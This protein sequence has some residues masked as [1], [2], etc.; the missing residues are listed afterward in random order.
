M[1]VH[2]VSIER[3]LLLR[4]LIPNMVIGLLE[5]VERRPILNSTGHFDGVVGHKRFVAVRHS[6]TSDTEVVLPIC[7][8]LELVF[9]ED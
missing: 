9:H 4:C 5:H 7:N 2:V 3:Q 8:S 1:L 6:W